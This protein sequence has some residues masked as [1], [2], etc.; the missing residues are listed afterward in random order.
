MPTP[1]SASA[2]R[3]SLIIG[4]LF[5][6]LVLSLAAVTILVMTKKLAPTTD[7]VAQ[8]CKVQ[9]EGAVLDATREIARSCQGNNAEVTTLPA[10]QHVPT[11]DASPGFDYPTDWSVRAG[12]SSQD[13]RWSA[14][15]VPGYFF[16]CEGCDG[17]AINVSMLMNSKTN[18]EVTSQT[19]FESFVRSQYADP[20]AFQNVQMQKIALASSTQYIV[21]GQ[22][23]GLYD[24]NFETLFFEG[25]TTYLTVTYLDL[26]ATETTTNTAWT[27][28]KNS[29]DVSTLK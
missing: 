26:D 15:L 4:L 8:A 17:P 7:S 23:L 28:I 2:R 16:E 13:V 12:V 3:Q 11:T 5:F 9:V 29:L 27:I 24:A 20:L 21:T 10:T 18:P 6:V 25:A 1:P 22:T 19:T 14:K